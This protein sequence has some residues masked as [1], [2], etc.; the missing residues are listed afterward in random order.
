[1]NHDEI[2]TMLQ[3]MSAYDSRK[4]DGPSI[5]AWK[6]AAA[7]AHWRSRDALES[8]HE[9]YAKSTAW[10]MPGHVTELIRASK[11]HPAPVGEVL[12]L[13]TAPPASAER[14]AALMAEIRSLADSKKV[15]Q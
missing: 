8:I 10:L 9:H 13:P 6:E 14:R 11:R 2:V 5:A 4:I 3:I 7:R 15:D 1:M 12:S